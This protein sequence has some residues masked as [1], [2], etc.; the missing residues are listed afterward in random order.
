MER[1]LSF[2]YVLGAL[3]AEEEQKFELQLAA[4]PKLYQAVIGWENSF[5]P[6]ADAVPKMQNPIDF[7]SIEAE[8]FP[9]PKINWLKVALFTIITL[10]V[11]KGAIAVGLVF[12]IF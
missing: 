4:D 9:K 10:A 7:R 3:S 6:L 1:D 11:I 2:E 8:L 5:A 12:A